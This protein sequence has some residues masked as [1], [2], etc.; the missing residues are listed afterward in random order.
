MPGSK[1]VPPNTARSSRAALIPFTSLPRRAEACTRRT[2]AVSRWRASTT[3]ARRSVTTS[4]PSAPCRAA[5]SG[6]GY[7][8]AL[9][10]AEG[11]DVASDS[12]TFE[13]PHGGVGPL[14][15]KMEALLQAD[16][17]APVT[18]GMLFPD[19]LQRFVPYPVAYFDRARAFE[20]SAEEAWS[21]VAGKD[22]NPLR[23]AFWRHWRADGSS[24]MLFLG[25]TIAENGQ[26][27]V[28][29]PV[30]I[31]RDKSYNVIDLKSLRE[32]TGSRRRTRRAAQHRDEL[33]RALS[34]GDAGRPRGDADQACAPRRWRLL[35]QLRYRGRRAADRPAAGEH[36]RYW[37]QHRLFQLRRR[38]ARRN[39]RVRVPQHRAYRLRQ[40]ARSLQVRR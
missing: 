23:E 38:P 20:A 1:A 22:R 7:L 16:L 13:P 34:P 14:E 6:A 9:L 2:L 37:A 24:P 35:R 25:A 19:L 40:P 17:L 39:G 18:A 10:N 5:A 28:I 32:S 4:S 26:Q 3:C 27:V 15:S 29:A 11:D 8:S 30:N 21:A 31:R 12:C 36:L 33:E